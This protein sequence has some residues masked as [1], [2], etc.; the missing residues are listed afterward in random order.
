MITRKIENDIQDVLD[1]AELEYKIRFQD[2]SLIIFLPECELNTQYIKSFHEIEK[3]YEFFPT[4]TPKNKYLS[5]EDKKIIGQ[6]NHVISRIS[7]LSEI[8]F[9]NY[10]LSMDYLPPGMYLNFFFD[11][12]K[13]LK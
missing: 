7:K 5:L 4:I 3:E 13:L 2:D 10:E 1:D 12:N 8:P 9:Y 6:K 11:E